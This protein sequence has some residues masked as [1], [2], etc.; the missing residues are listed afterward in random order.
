MSTRFSTKIKKTFINKLIFYRSCSQYIPKIYYEVVCI[1]F[2]RL[3]L[4][5]ILSPFH[6]AEAPALKLKREQQISALQSCN[7]YVEILLMD[8]ELKLIIK[9]THTPYS[10]N[11]RNN[12]TRIHIGMWGSTASAE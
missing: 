4:L 8:L 3:L 2:I 12:F 11:I 1:V 6:F 9:P 10:G 7:I 5:K